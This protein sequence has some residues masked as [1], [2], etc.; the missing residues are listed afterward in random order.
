MPAAPRIDHAAIQHLLTRYGV[1]GARVQ[2]VAH[3]GMQVFRVTPPRASPGEELALRVYLPGLDR[4]Q[5]ESELCWLDAMAQEG[6]HVP[7]PRADLEEQ[8]LQP[9]PGT[10]PGEP[11]RCAVILRWLPG[12]CL[13][14]GLQPAHLQQ[15]GRLMG[16]MHA[17][18]QTLVAS[19]RIASTQKTYV[20]DLRRWASGERARSP[21]ISPRA[22]ELA[23]AAAARLLAELSSIPKT[24]PHHGYIH[25]D[26]H[27]WNLLFHQGRAGLI[28]FSDCGWG[29]TALELAAALQ[30]LK[31]PLP[32]Q[33]AHT[34]AYPALRDSLLSA[35][36]AQRT[37]PAHFE[38]HVEAYIGARMVSTLEWVLADWPHIGHRAWGPAFLA[39]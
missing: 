19:G 25:G 13:S 1:R 39:G 6:L 11:A 21:H 3:L 7:A 17:L 10:A 33:R 12:R 16:R 34:I 35:Y 32:I 30:Y 4:A 8:L 15:V 18:S 20:A 27:L 36:A 23:C 22:H 2:R 29:D 31:H 37:L 26:A 38:R 14:S 5:I 28:D 24:A 9:F